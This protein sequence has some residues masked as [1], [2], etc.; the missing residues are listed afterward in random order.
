MASP[1]RQPLAAVLLLF[2]PLQVVWAL[3][4]EVEVQGVDGALEKNV[5]AAL[6]IVAAAQDSRLTLARLR[7]LTRLAPREASRALEPFGHYDARVTVQLESLSNEVWRVV[8]KVEPGPPVTVGT[9]VYRILGEGAEDPLFPNRPPFRPGDI[10]FHAPWEEFKE[11]L[12]TLALMNGYLDARLTRSRILVDL[13]RHTADLE[14]EL[15][16]GP[17]YH[18][19]EVRIQQDFLD[20][21]LMR[22]LV[23]ELEGLRY[24]Q[25]RI[26]SLQRALID[27]GYFSSVEIEPVREAAVDGRMPIEIRLRPRDRDRYRVGVGY[28]TDEGPRVTFQ[29]ERRLL[30]SEGHSAGVRLRLSPVESSFS[31]SYRIPGRDPRNDYFALEPELEYHDSEGRTGY[32]ATLGLIHYRLRGDWQQLVGLEYTEERNELDDGSIQRFHELVPSIRLTRRIQD[33][34]RRTLEGH[35]LDFELLGAL[36]PLWSTGSYVKGRAFGKWI[37]AFG[38]W[39][40]VARAEV[41]IIWS[42]TLDEVPASRR[43]YAGGDNS[44]RGYRYE[45]LALRDAQGRLVGG[46]RLGVASLELNRLIGTE[47]AGSLFVDGGGVWDPDLT[48]RTAWGAGFG[49]VWFSP[50][51]PVRVDLAFPMNDD[52]VSGPRLH[53]SIGPEL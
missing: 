26:L 52:E 12:L 41:G 11:E 51:G 42:N 7:R 50:V 32:T 35:R 25:Q 53:L 14:L 10:L 17:A 46:R 45:S 21:E 30:N 36:E 38:H 43:F 49:A 6:S 20:P 31:G 23:G 39:R 8:V 37:H 33:D 29:W 28:A 15:D 44:V 48:R 34:P 4:L 18:L 16:T 24:T 2:L 3:D 22:G 1:L 40:L 47:W 5:R 19:G 27:T 13:R 9:M